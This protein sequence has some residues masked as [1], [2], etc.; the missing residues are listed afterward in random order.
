MSIDHYL[1]KNFRESREYGEMHELLK[2]I[3]VTIF[4]KI[5]YVPLLSTKEIQ[6]KP[7]R[8]IPKSSKVEPQALSTVY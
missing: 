5:P 1:E 3:G 6:R 4:G 2:Y 8:I 7:S